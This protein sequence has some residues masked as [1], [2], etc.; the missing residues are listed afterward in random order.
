MTQQFRLNQVLDHARLKEEAQATELST[1]D[2]EHR[3]A[4]EA[5]QQ[6]RE[7][8]ASQLAA[9]SDASNAGSFDPAVIE[10]SRHYLA[11]LESS[12]SE[13]LAHVSAMA[14]AVEASRTALLALSREKRLLERLEEQH[15]DGV[16]ADTLRREN[17]HADE[18]NGQRFQRAR[19]QPP[20]EVA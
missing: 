11:R 14:T 19:Q 9:L 18:L 17:A 12:I 1:L 5:L 6:L 4:L 16:A 8:E 10:A 7:Q 15:D 2:A 20:R 13:Q 3:R